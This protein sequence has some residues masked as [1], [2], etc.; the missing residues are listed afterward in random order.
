[1][2]WKE[3]CNKRTAKQVSPDN[4]MILALMKS[5]ENKLESESKL[6]MTNVTASSKLSLAYDSLREL[7]EALALKKG[8]KVYNHECYTA[9]IKEIIGESDKGEDFNELRKERNSVNYYGKEI[10]AE[11]ASK[12]IERIRKL[13]NAMAALVSQEIIANLGDFGTFARFAK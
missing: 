4:D 9:F 12:T 3:C 11:D 7:L 6:E 2:D 10:S 1:M 13:R 5:S 8:Y